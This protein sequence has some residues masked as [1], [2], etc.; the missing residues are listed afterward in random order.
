MP[1]SCHATGDAHSIT[2]SAAS[3]HFVDDDGI[4]ALMP[5]C[6]AQARMP[7]YAADACRHSAIR[8]YAT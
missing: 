8:Y 7:R 5:V 6:F 2:P 4:Y 1:R 3:R